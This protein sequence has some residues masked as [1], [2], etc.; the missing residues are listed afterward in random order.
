MQLKT[1]LS[2]LKKIIKESGSCLIAFSGGAD[3]AFLLKIASLALAKEKIIAVTAKSATYPEEE[4]NSAK[5]IAA[6]FGVRHKI[7]NTLELND[8]R[9]MANPINRCYFCKQRLFTK[10]KQTAR[11]HRLKFIF[12]ASNTSDN[13]DYRPGQKAKK[14]LGIRS[15]LEEAGITKADI[16]ALS[17]EL[18][19]ITWDKP[20]L[21][22]L[23]SRIPYGINI[24]K[25]ILSRINKAENILRELK[26]RQ[27]RVRHYNG[28]C[29]IEVP[30]KD[31]SRLVQQSQSLIDKF[32]KLG[33]NYI[34]LDLE[35]YRT[36]SMNEIITPHCRVGNDTTG[37]S[38]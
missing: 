32:K 17:R 35:G 2:R 25:P 30:K 23:A 21:A 22:C 38:L 5:K 19:L 8:Q 31:I 4:L 20:S 12:D 10:L 18:G 13:S 15:P 9:F 1:K 28:L 37:G 14:E 16:R 26:F 34:T 29:R 27:V 3:S 11:K 36:G 33:Y 7:I 24:S 6:S